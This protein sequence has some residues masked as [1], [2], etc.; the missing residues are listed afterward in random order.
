[1]PLARWAYSFTGNT[2]NQPRKFAGA[3]GAAKRETDMQI[4]IQLRTKDTLSST[5][6]G[7]KTIAFGPLKSNSGISEAVINEH[8]LEIISDSLRSLPHKLDETGTGT[9]YVAFN[10][11]NW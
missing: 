5:L 4:A 6:E 10:G 3:A 1:V 7:A 9:R 2:S 11:A 8:Q